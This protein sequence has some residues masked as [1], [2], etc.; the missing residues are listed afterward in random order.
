MAID[1]T[2]KATGGERFRPAVGEVQHH[3]NGW[4]G[5][6]K[7][8]A[9][10]YAQL[11]KDGPAVG[12]VSHRPGQAAWYG[13]DLEGAEEYAQLAAGGPAVGDVSHRPGQAAWYGAD[14]IGADDYAQLAAG[15]PAA[16][17]GLEKSTTKMSAPELF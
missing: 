12:D 3:V 16:G 15:G 7:I 4:I 14:K 2:A 9:D 1:S 17:V 6:N 5:A 8:G 13:A 10:D 11:A